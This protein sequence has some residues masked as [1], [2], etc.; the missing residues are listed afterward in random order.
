MGSAFLVLL[1]RHLNKSKFKVDPFK[2]LFTITS[3]NLAIN[4]YNTNDRETI[5][6]V[7]SADHKSKKVFINKGGM[8]EDYLNILLE[9]IQSFAPH[10]EI[11]VNK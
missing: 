5:G 1:L 11:E 9:N 6:A 7:I 2:W 3:D 4:V 10:A 8:D